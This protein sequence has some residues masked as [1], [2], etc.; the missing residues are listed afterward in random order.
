MSKNNEA[1]QS[2]I[3]RAIRKIAAPWITKNIPFPGASVAEIANAAGIQS[4][5]KAA[6]ILSSGNIRLV[7]NNKLYSIA[8][9]DNYNYPIDLENKSQL[10]R[11]ASYGWSV[12]RTQYRSRAP[13]GGPVVKRRI[14]EQALEKK[15]KVS[16]IRR[17]NVL[18]I[19]QKTV[20][21][22][23]KAPNG[24]LTIPYVVTKIIDSFKRRSEKNGVTNEEELAKR[25]SRNFLKQK[26]QPFLFVWGPPYQRQEPNE[27]LFSS[28]SPEGI[29]KTQIKAFL[30]KIT[31][32]GLQIKP[33]LLYADS[34]GTTINGLPTTLVDNYGNALRAEF[35]SDALFVPWSKVK[36]ENNTRYTQLQLDVA[37]QFIPSQKEIIQAANIAQTLGKILSPPEIILAAKQYGVERTI[38]GIMLSEGFNYRG[39][40][41]DGIIKLGTAPSREKNDDPYES[42]LPRIYLKNSMRAPWNRKR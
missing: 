20:L 3:I 39:N 42:T 29:L 16:G 11:N 18:L 6:K 24:T 25:L 12:Q 2:N 9:L 38:E 8:L 33:I 7:N 22:K 27:K 34:Y 4:E 23:L 31:T 35:S 41:I 5:E 15:L 28:S 37:S 13:G 19:E 17:A 21:P 10:T 30:Q 40:R 36:A 1:D 26:D 32:P 14:N